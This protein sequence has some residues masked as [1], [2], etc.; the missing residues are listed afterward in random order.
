[1]ISR[2][3]RS[4]A[5]SSIVALVTLVGGCSDS[6][7]ERSTTEEVTGADAGPSCLSELGTPAGTHS[8][9]GDATS[10]DV[11]VSERSALVQADGDP[12]ALGDTP[13]SGSLAGTVARSVSAAGYLL[14]TQGT[15][16]VG[17]MLL[18]DDPG[19]SWSGPTFD[20]LNNAHVVGDFVLARSG[21]GELSAYSATTGEPVEVSVSEDEV[22]DALGSRVPSSFLATDSGDVRDL[23][24]GE[25]I[26]EEEVGNDAY[27]LARSTD[28]VL[29]A[30]ET[31]NDGDEDVTTELHVWS[32]DEE[33]RK[34]HE[35]PGREFTAALC[36]NYLYLAQTGQ[37]VVLDIAG[38]DAEQVAVVPFSEGEVVD[39]QATRGS[40]VV[41]TGT[42]HAEDYG[43]FTASWF[44]GPSS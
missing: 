20:S 44:T 19:D 31:W 21:T 16:G 10:W 37:I 9:E 13:Q 34:V 14:E 41:V 43:T 32:A 18:G 35:V 3:R 12:V 6:V 27:L 30:S 2:T 26:T 7:V 29:F 39:I 33:L 28:R 5:T 36:D 1:M 4:I 17:L 25:E 40:A 15:D 22:A 8:W 42:S 24:S 38:D 23:Q 11:F